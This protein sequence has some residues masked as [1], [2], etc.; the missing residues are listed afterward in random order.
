MTRNRPQ[1]HR[2]NRFPGRLHDVL[3]D[4]LSDPALA[5][6]ISWEPSGT[7]F[8]IH[9]QTSFVAKVIPR[10]FPKMKSYKSFR[11]QLNLY[12]LKVQNPAEST[13]STATGINQ[14]NL[15]MVSK[16]KIKVRAVKNQRNEGK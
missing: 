1:S 16:T 8:K 3:E 5:K 13:H 6:V 15:S 14:D 9:D 2:T 11:R 7:A 10:Y 4:A 12:G